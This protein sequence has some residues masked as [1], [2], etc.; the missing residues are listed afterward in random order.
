MTSDRLTKYQ[1]SK[2]M[3]SVRSRRTSI[4]LSVRSVIQELHLRCLYNVK[5]LPGTPDIVI[6][7]RRAIVMVHGCFWHRHICSKGQSAPE[8]H[9]DFWSA[10]FE[11]NKRRDRSAINQ[12][13]RLGWRVIVVWECQVKRPGGEFIRS[14][15][16]KF[17]CESK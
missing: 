2:C 5:S 1:R 4:E 13:R 10:K 6:P 9:K 17:L 14:K 12:L 16:S 15:L 7:S 11:R 3:S 8:S